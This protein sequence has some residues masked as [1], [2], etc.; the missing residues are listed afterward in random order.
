LYSSV[1]EACNLI[2]Y[3]NDRKGTKVDIPT[4]AYALKMGFLG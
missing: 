2:F 4:I 1:I 3:K